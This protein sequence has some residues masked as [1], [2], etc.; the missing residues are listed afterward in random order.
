M[1]SQLPNYV[2]DQMVLV[3]ILQAILCDTH[4][5]IV[6]HDQPF[7]PPSRSST[8][9]IQGKYSFYTKARKG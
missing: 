3:L 4:F 7:H 1:I 2:W 5:H 9:I 8:N 6:S